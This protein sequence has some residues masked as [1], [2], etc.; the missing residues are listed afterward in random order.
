MDDDEDSTSIVSI[1]DSDIDYYPHTR[2]DVCSSPCGT[3]KGATKHDSARPSN[4]FI[5]QIADCSPILVSTFPCDSDSPHATRRSEIET[6]DVS[7][8]LPGSS[9]FNEPEFST[10][11]HLGNGNQ[12]GSMP[13]LND[14]AVDNSL[15]EAC[16]MLFPVIASCPGGEEPSLQF[17]DNYENESSRRNIFN[18][19][20]D[21]TPAD[22]SNQFE[23]IQ[24]ASSPEVSQHTRGKRTRK[25][26]HAGFTAM[27][28]YYSLAVCCFSRTGIIFTL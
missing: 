16:D 20:P 5:R 14:C 11:L 8:H 24:V 6:F 17:V 28:M 9:S 3:F 13:S 1:A 22:V 4:A 23:V 7:N 19:Q 27:L 10:L 25:K 21:I 15:D 18:A 26:R 12:E 2:E